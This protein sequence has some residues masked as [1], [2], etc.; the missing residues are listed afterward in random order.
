MLYRALFTELAVGL[1]FGVGGGPYEQALRIVK[2]NERCRGEVR[3][4]AFCS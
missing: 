3:D 1:K 2:W 4:P